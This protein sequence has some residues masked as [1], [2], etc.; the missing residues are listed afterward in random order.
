MFDQIDRELQTWV[1][2]VAP[3]QAHQITL[4]AP[5]I[6]SGI[7]SLYLMQVVRVMT[8]NESLRN[9]PAPTTIRL[10]Y[11][12][13]VHHDDPLEAHKLLGTL[14]FAALEEPAYEVDLELLPLA[15]WA[16]FQQLPQ[17]AFVLKV[18][19]RRERPERDVQLVRKP[20]NL[21]SASLTTLRGVILGPDDIPL[22]GAVIEL[23]ALGRTQRTDRAGAFEF[24]TVPVQPRQRVSIRAKGRVFEREIE[25][26]LSTAADPVIIRIDL[27]E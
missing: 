14:M 3:V 1:S 17:P 12:V 4:F 15:A 11:L 23:P 8:A 26:R 16:S 10:H 20:L 7:V 6:K 13:T 22:H 9:Q 19:L 24:E 2:N 18:P 27:D 5:G 21:Q 25:S